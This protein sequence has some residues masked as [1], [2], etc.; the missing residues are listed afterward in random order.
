MSKNSDSKYMSLA[1]NLAKKAQGMTN[2]N[3]VV[4]AV[5]VRNGKII[6]KGYH[7]KAGLPHAEIEAIKNAKKLGNKI[8]GSTLYITL[9][10]CCH[11]NK[12][13]PPLFRCIAGREIF[14]CGNWH[15][16]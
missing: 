6:G 13:T 16:R 11:K 12:R 10:P 4:G 1:I 5:I 15:I 8:S 9:E 14:T 3:P 7:S 2:P